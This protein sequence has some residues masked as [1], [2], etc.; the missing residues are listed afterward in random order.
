MSNPGADITIHELFINPEFTT[1]FAEWQRLGAKHEQLSDS[2]FNSMVD[3]RKSDDVALTDTKDTVEYLLDRVEDIADE[4]LSEED[5]DIFFID[6]EF[7]LFKDKRAT[8]KSEEAARGS[9]LELGQAAGLGQFAMFGLSR[10]VSGSGHNTTLHRTEARVQTAEQR[11]SDFTQ[12]L[13]SYAGERVLSIELGAAW[14]SRLAPGSAD[15]ENNTLKLPTQRA[16]GIALMD[17]PRHDSPLLFEQDYIGVDAR[18]I[19][20]GNRAI[21][22]TGK[23]LEGSWLLGRAGHHKLVVGQLPEGPLDLSR[24][25]NPDDIDYYMDMAARVQTV[26]KLVA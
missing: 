17:F 12:T 11:L 10:Y 8:A 13:A 7:D 22:E 24:V 9:L 21:I 15:I 4:S 16:Y 20:E 25:R 1:Q 6:G 23:A 3:R 26:I 18:R 19:V 5:A 2:L 14:A